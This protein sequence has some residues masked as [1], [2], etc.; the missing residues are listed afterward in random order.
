MEDCNSTQKKLFFV[1]NV[2]SFFISHRLPLALEALKEEYEVWLLTADTGRR[3]ELE[4]LGIHFIT[5]PFKRSGRNPF[6]E[7]KCLW[8]LC[9]HYHHHHPDIIHHITLKAALLGSLAAKLTLS[10]Q[11]INALSGLGYNFT[12]ERNGL[13]QQIIQILV[14]LAF[15][16]KYFSFILQNPDDVKMIQ[17]LHLVPS[18]NIY[19]IKGSGID[20]ELFKYTY[21][22]KKE[23]LQILFPARILLDKG[24]IEFIEA[25]KAI[26]SKM[27][28]KV[29]FLLAGD[30]DL[31]NLSVLTE[32]NLSPLLEPNYI[33]WIGFQKNMYTIY[34]YSDIVVLPSYRE[35]LPKSLIEASAVGRP[36]ITTDVPGCRECVRENWNGFLV[37]AKDSKA[38]AEAIL[39]LIENENLRNKFGENSRRL[40]EQQF[41]LSEVVNRHMNIYSNLI[42][43]SYVNNKT[44]KN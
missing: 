36:I 25:A 42:V 40:A 14:Q 38:L 34:Q 18:S 43:S 41:S 33:E 8:L 37:P 28:G 13:L 32:E 20:L 11:V 12:N 22:R 31:E 10:R 30:C 44:Q 2:D 26:R 6:H 3:K 17:E 24:V 35:G 21:P 1:V 15:K 16:S 27:K 39:K 29:L 19:L 9:K 7:L 5:I 23:K 4:I